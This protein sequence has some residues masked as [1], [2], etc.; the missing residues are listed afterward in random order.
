MTAFANTSP[1]DVDV[2]DKITMVIDGLKTTT[3]QIESLKHE[4][5]LNAGFKTIE[6]YV[7]QVD[8]GAFLVIKYEFSGSQFVYCSN[9]LSDRYDEDT[10]L[11]R[12]QNQE[13]KKLK[14][15]KP[16]MAFVKRIDIIYRC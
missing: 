16:T 10:K 14:I 4:K 15:L 9:I 6:M 8:Q 1:P 3:V 7:N 2:G 13:I 12:R 5:R 11:Q